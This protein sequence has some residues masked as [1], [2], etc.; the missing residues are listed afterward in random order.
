VRAA[1]NHLRAERAGG[2]GS[3]KLVLPFA[4]IL[5]PNFLPTK[6][7]CRDQNEKQLSRS[8]ANHLRE[9]A[10]G[11]L[12]GGWGQGLDP[13]RKKLQTLAA[14]R[15]RCVPNYPA[16]AAG[17]TEPEAERGAEE[18]QTQADVRHMMASTQQRLE[19]DSRKSEF[20]L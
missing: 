16:L 20:V 7:S 5:L 18:L 2:Q 1:A 17:K 13:G 3:K 10:L 11:L 19:K 4:Q 15:R 8:A 14:I 9:T 12:K 6:T